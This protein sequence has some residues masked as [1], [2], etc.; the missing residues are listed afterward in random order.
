MRFPKL[1]DLDRDQTAI[2][3]GAP[4]EGS[5]LI[6][7]PPGTGK[8]VIAFHR[9]HYLSNLGRNPRVMMYSKVLVQYAS[10]RGEIAQGVTVSTL[11]SWLYRWWGSFMGKRATPPKVNGSK[12]EHNWPIIQ[13]HTLSTITSKRQLGGVNWGHLIIDEGQDF[14]P[15]MYQALKIIMDVANAKGAKP[16]LAVTVLADENQRLTS[17]RNATIEDIRINLG[18][19]PAAENVFL[20]KKNY[21][22]TKEIATF[23]NFFYAGLPSGIPELPTRT[24]DLPVVS[25]ISRDT[26]D[27][28]LIACADKIGRYAKIRRTEEIAVLVM[29]NIERKKML[30]C[31]ADRLNGS[32]VILQSY[33]S[34]DANWPAQNLD[35]DTPG[36]VTVLNYTSAKGLEFDAVFL[37]DPGKL[38][39]G[40]SSEIN[41]KMA[42]YVMCSRA[43]AMLNVMLIGDTH[44][45]TLLS[46]IP[47][48]SGV[49]EL[50]NI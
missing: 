34:N 3:Q 1:T 41:T 15:L 9:A 29:G 17:H 47:T 31:L 28:F 20:L 8:S 13:F 36:H 24:G 21:R 43:R 12:F 4:P 27:S 38:M 45:K 32:G 10:N 35:F 19:Y 33:A 40:G 50:E 16:P 26:H 18:L 14:S 46:W 6:V 37:I 11:H 44:M 23:S 30:T 48:Q 42:L 39:H 25:I 5:V 7:G 49:Y 2:Y 22:N